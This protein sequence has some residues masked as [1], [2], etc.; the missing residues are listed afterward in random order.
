[1]DLQ[2]YT[3]IILFMIIF[4][5]GTISSGKSTVAKLLSSKI[6]NTAN[7]EID[8]LRD[9][10]EFMPL[11]EAISIN[12][13]NAVLIIRNFVKHGLN[14]VVPYPLSEKNYLYLQD[15]LRDLNEKIFVF[16]I[17]PSIDSLL[18]DGRERKLNDWEKK[19]INYHHEIGLTA[20]TFGEIIDS[21]NQTP[22]ETAE[23]IT[24]RISKQ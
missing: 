23:D 7:I 2:A 22:E 12:L 11:D 3:V 9:F 14:V 18:K 20:P 15:G 5:N 19:R 21:T 8:S 16:T 24:R 1:M 6:P 13:E 17:S 4:L 10:I